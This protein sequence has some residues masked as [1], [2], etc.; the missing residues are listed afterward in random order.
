MSQYKPTAG[1]TA[2][3][4]IEW[5]T[6]NPDKELTIDDIEAKF[7][8]A[9][10]QLHSL[11][12]QAVIS[13]ALTRAT[14]DSDEIVYRLGT[15][16]A[17]IVPSHARNPT[18]RPDVLLSGG[19]VG[20][21]PKALRQLAPID[22]DELVL[23][24]DVPVPKIRNGVNWPSFLFKFTKVGQSCVLP[25]SIRASLNKEIT[26]SKKSSLSQFVLRK[27]DAETFGIWRVK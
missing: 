27:V 13:G 19:A 26:I 11:L 7:D 8:Q 9:A 25:N 15:G 16:V 6:T 4:V 10:K 22:L 23:R 2:Y 20:H 24:D 3:K 1:S 12:G 14:N 17:S 18:L 21:Q 5:L